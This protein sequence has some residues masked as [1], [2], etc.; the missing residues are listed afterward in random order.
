M[1]VP[2]M[3]MVKRNLK[4]LFSNTISVCSYYIVADDLSLIHL[5]Y[6]SGIQYIVIL[7]TEQRGWCVVWLLIELCQFTACP[8]FI[9]S[10]VS[11]IFNW[12]DWQHWIYAGFSVGLWLGN[13]NLKKHLP[14]VTQLAFDTRVVRAAVSLTAKYKTHVVVRI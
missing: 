11:L 6:R 8:F 12:Y 5:H 3:S 2:T 13:L 7:K 4:K 9:P 10:Y 14:N 1:Y